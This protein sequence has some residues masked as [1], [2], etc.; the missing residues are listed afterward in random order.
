MT[1]LILHHF[2]YLTQDLHCTIYLLGS[3]SKLESFVRSRLELHPHDMTTPWTNILY[4]DEITAGNGLRHHN[5][6]K[7][8]AYYWSF[9]EFGIEAL[10]SEFLWFTQ[11]L[12]R[13]D[14][15]TNMQ[16]HGWH[17]PALQANDIMLCKYGN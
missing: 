10:T 16:G 13:S 17:W 1:M 6:R 15:V 8:Q 14:Y 3:S 12:V 5:H 11:L 9:L 4:N 7:V 2:G